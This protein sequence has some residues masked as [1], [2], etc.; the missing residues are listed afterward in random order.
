MGNDADEAVALCQRVQHVQRLV[1]HVVAQRT[2]ALV[3]EQRVEPLPAGVVL[4]D[5]GQAERQR[6][7]SDEGLAAGQTA[8]RPPLPRA[9]IQ[10]VDLQAGFGV[11]PV[12]AGPVHQLIAAA[13]HDVQPMVGHFEDLAEDCAHHI[14]VKA[15]LAAVARRSHGQIA[16]P[17]HTFPGGRGEGKA[18]E[19]RARPVIHGLVRAQ[20]RAHPGISF[21]SLSIDAFRREKPFRQFRRVD[22]LPAR[23]PRG[24]A[25]DL[26]L[27]VLYV[28]VIR[29]QELPFR[30]Q[31]RLAVLDG[32]ERVLGLRCA[33]KAGGGD[34]GVHGGAR[35]RSGLFPAG[36][37]AVLVFQHVLGDV[38]LPVCG[39][40]RVQVILQDRE[41]GVLLVFQLPLPHLGGL[42][43]VIG[44]RLPTIGVGKQRFGSGEQRRLPGGDVG[45]QR[46]DG[47][48][49]LAAF[50]FCGIGRRLCGIDFRLR[51]SAVPQRRQ[52]RD[53]VPAES[54][55]AYRTRRLAVLGQ[56]LRQPVGQDACLPGNE[57]LIQVVVLLLGGACPLRRSPQGEFFFRERSLRGGDRRHLLLQRPVIGQLVLDPLDA[58]LQ[59]ARVRPELSVSRRERLRPFSFRGGFLELFP[60]LRDPAPRSLQLP[61]RVPEAVDLRLG[62]VQGGVRLFHSETSFLYRV[63]P[64]RQFA[65]AAAFLLQLA[66]LP[67]EL[68]R[69]ALLRIES[70]GGGA[71]RI[72]NLSALLERR[73]LRG[74]ER[75]QVLPQLRMVRQVALRVLRASSGQNKTVLHQLPQ[76]VLCPG[77]AAAQLVPRAAQQILKVQIG[78]VI[79]QLAEDLVFLAAVRF[80]KL[81]EFPL[82]QHDDLAELLPVEADQLLAAGGHPACA[83]RRRGV[84]LLQER[85]DDRRT[86]E[87]LRA[88]LFGEVDGPRRCI[89]FPV[90][91]KTQPD[92]RIHGL[93]HMVAVHHLRRAVRAAR[94]AV[95]SE[96]Y[97][98]EDRGLAC[99]GVPGDKIQAVLQ[100]RER[101]G[102]FLRV[103]AEG[104]HFKMDRSH[105]PA[106]CSCRNARSPSTSAGSGVARYRAQR[107]SSPARRRSSAS[108]PDRPQPV[109][110]AQKSENSSSTAFSRA[111]GEA[112]ASVP[113]ANGRCSETSS[114]STLS[115]AAARSRKNAAIS[116][117][118]RRSVST[119]RRYSPR[120]FDASSRSRS[121]SKPPRSSRMG[122]SGGRWTVSITGASPF[123]PSVTRSGPFAGCR[124]SLKW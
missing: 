91:R 124:V 32:R 12:G 97:R 94:R 110:S 53:M 87:L 49:A 112:G 45:Q 44:E 84:R 24:Q 93:R 105:A 101:H 41:H 76:P 71:C 118:T 36:K 7:R 31:P 99:A 64:L 114:I 3:D 116:G 92:L 20:E 109:R 122:C 117:V 29:G 46:A 123:A 111:S 14:A 104:G 60:E 40:Q 39:V 83:L 34:R 19:I 6:Q 61:L 13:A 80:Q 54:R 103:G 82:R 106:S 79:E 63:L 98:V 120:V 58:G 42:Q 102:G 17:L 28:A 5:V 77:A 11:A 75:R 1:Q 50:G 85:V 33:G 21:V 81:P 108:A 100:L 65:F 18:V 57:A 51:G 35:L 48:F 74:D 89:L 73:L 25:L 52:R 47:F 30:G 55:T 96:H 90:L 68:V 38:V 115:R 88:A 107:C 113:P 37:R 66:E 62:N 59:L 4:H 56:R 15:Q 121:S 78:S 70:V 67:V 119:T 72:A 16:Q 23:Q 22:A 27:C 86:V 10:H 95:E 8:G 69:R 26:L 9:E 43:Q 2:E